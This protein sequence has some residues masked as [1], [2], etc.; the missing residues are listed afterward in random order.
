MLEARSSPGE[1]VKAGGSL[2]RDALRIRSM[3]ALEG[4]RWIRS[5]RHRKGL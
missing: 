3:L 1:M 2:I 4:V 5:S